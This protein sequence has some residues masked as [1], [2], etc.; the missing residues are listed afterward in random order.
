[1]TIAATATYTWKPSVVLPAPA[2]LVVT[3]INVRPGDALAAGDIVAHVNGVSIKYFVLESPLYQPVCAADTALVDE[4]RAVLKAEYLPTATT[5]SLSQTD[6]RSIRTYA[7]GIGV[8]DY[9]GLQCFEPGW[10]A[11]TDAPIGTIGEI[12]LSLGAPATAQGVAIVTGVPQLA[13]ITCGTSGASEIDQNLDAEG[14][15]AFAST[16]LIVNGVPTGVSLDDL[17][18]SETLEVLS[19]LFDPTLATAPVA[20]A[21]GLGPSQ[22]I[23]PATTVVNPTSSGRLPRCRRR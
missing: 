15:A 5:K 18:K 14:D 17:S 21:L 7:R 20:V 8:T 13:A 10:I 4:V 11:S 22:F 1:M 16:E 9:T 6:V 12:A 23:V 2:W 19:P 3:A